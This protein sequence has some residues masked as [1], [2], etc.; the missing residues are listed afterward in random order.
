MTTGAAPGYVDDKACAVCHRPLYDSYQEVGMAKSFSRPQTDSAIEDFTQ[1][2]LFH[3]PSQQ[4][5]A[6]HRRDTQ[7][8]FKRYQLDRHGKPINVFEQQVDWILGSGHTSRTYLY[9]TAGGELY[10][11][12]LV[13]YSQIKRWGMAPGFDRPRHDGVLR[14][15]RREC[16]FCHNAYPNVPSQTDTFEGAHTFPTELPQGLD[17]QRCHGPGAEHVRQAF[18]GT[19]PIEQIRATIINP[20]RLAPHVRDDVCFQCHLQPSVA[21]PGLRWF[22]RSDYSFRP[23]QPLGEYLVQLDVQE[24]GKQRTERSPYAPILSRHGSTW[25]VSMPNKGVS[26]MPSPAIAAP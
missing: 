18:R 26:T 24:E 22:H 6:M 12:S 7:L 25:G 9:Q 21:L 20:K 13:W 10:Q 19:L 5:F 11:L 17:C 15:V 1:P 16:L 14:R 3:A 8:Y 2:D 4:Y 23:G